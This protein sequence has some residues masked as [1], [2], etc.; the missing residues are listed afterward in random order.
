MQKNEVSLERVDT[1]RSYHQV[2]IVGAGAAGIATAASLKKR[3]RSL[4]I[5]VIDF[6][7][8]HYYQPGWTLLG[9]GILDAS[10]TA[11]PIEAVVPAG[12]TR[13]EAKVTAVDPV[14]HTVRLHDGSVVSYQQLVVCPGLELDWNGIPGLAET[15]GRNGV[16]SNYLFEL[17]PY[18]WE[19]TQALRRGPALFTQPPM[20][21]KCA[22][23]P[24]KAMYLAASYWQRAGCLSDMHVAFHSAASVLF[25]VSAYVPALMNYMQRYDIDLRLQSNLIAVDGA[26]RVATFKET[27]FDGRTYTVD[28]RF[29][30]LHAVPPQRAPDFIRTSSLADDTGW[31][32]VNAMTLSH[33]RFA[34]IHALGDVINTPNAKTAAAVRK[35]APVVAHN[36][37]AA[38][39]KV[40]G[41]ATYDGYGACPLTVEHEHV[42]LAE[43]TYGGKLAPSFPRWMI[44]GTQPSKLAWWLKVYGLPMCYW[45][46]MLRGREWLAKP[47]VISPNTRIGQ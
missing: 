10:K 24:Q 32:D 2:V 18:T 12:V 9:A 8:T 25:S 23:A 42:V 20:P 13:I 45:K 7:R 36:V 41:I 40:Q 22:G 3:D 34:N 44:D 15:L 14:G 46:W 5:A 1:S 37:L 21:I 30:M 26:R 27:T 39:G 28:R 43:F 17:A 16:T 19:M 29:E 38:L 4:D 31:C 6:S 33:K 11:K 47:P 35:Q